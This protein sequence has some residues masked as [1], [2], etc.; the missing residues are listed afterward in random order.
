MKIIYTLAILF[1]AFITSSVEQ[2]SYQILE[3]SLAPV[4]GACLGGVLACTSIV[5]SVLS[6]SSK[7]TKSKAKESPSFI[8]FVTS[9]E[10]DLKLLVLCLFSV[11]FLPYFRSLHYSLEISIFDIDSSYLKQKFFSTLEVFSSVIAFLI[12]FE[13]ISILITILKNMMN[14]H[15]TEI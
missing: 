8:S 12:I 14:I 3:K 11:I 9:L 6:A 15:D 4:L 1:I 7:Q 2:D 13:L 10:K 5:I